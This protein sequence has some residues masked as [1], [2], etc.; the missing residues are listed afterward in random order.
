LP[1]FT[2]SS[3]APS[4]DARDRLVLSHKRQ[5]THRVIWDCSSPPSERFRD[6]ALDGTGRPTRASM[7]D[8]LNRERWLDASQEQPILDV[9][10]Q[11]RDGNS[12]QPGTQLAAETKSVQLSKQRCRDFAPT[13][14]DADVRSL[15]DQRS[16]LEENEPP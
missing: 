2:L 12:P 8:L 6:P 7:S 3:Q 16:P 1:G 13:T 5:V 10:R 4:C 14:S 11:S 9:G 15:L